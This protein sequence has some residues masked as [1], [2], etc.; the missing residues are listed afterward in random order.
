VGKPYDR[1]N[2]RTRY[3]KGEPYQAYSLRR[4]LVTAGGRGEFSP[5]ASNDTEAGKQCNRRTQIT[6]T[7]KFCQFMELIDKASEEK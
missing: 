7:P 5:I 3:I 6:I 4:P 1:T 2:L